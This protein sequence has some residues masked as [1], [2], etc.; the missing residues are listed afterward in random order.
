MKEFKLKVNMPQFRGD[1]YPP[2]EEN[3]INESKF[4]D[5]MRIKYWEAKEDGDTINIMWITQEEFDKWQFMGFMEEVKRYFE[6]IKPEG[7]KTVKLE[8]FCRSYPDVKTYG[9]INL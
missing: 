6:Y 7:I 4:A 2:F 3:A 1:D 5:E 9:E 8:V